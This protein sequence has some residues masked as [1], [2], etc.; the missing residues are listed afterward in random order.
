MNAVKTADGILRIRLN[1]GEVKPTDFVTLSPNS[2]SRGSKM[3]V[4]EGS[5]LTETDTGK[6]FIFDAE[7][8]WR[9]R[10]PIEAWQGGDY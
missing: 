9:E 1:S 6:S 3:T 5:V 4:Y 7:E 2:R 8:G 10:T